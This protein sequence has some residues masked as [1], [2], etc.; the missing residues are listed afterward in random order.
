MAKRR[1]K[2]M[3][4]THESITT[5]G[6]DGRPVSRV[7][8]H[9]GEDKTMTC[10]HRNGT[11]KNGY[12]EYRL[13]C[14]VCYNAKRKE[15]ANSNKHAEFVGHQRSRGET[16]IDYTYTEWRETVIFF[17]GQCAYCGATMRRN[18]TL[19]RDHLLPVSKGGK[20]AQGNIVP[21]CASDRK[22][23]RLNSIHFQ[24]YRMPSSA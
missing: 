17:G 1:A 22:S 20:T 12:P 4:G 16:A 7:C 2:R 24:K 18:Q 23:T 5:Y 15:N 6:G 19:T 21:A 3:Y 10:F 11:D 8:T 14:K 13:E 9:C